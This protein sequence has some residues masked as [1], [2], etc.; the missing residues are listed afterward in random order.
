MNEHEQ[1]NVGITKQI[2]NNEWI[3]TMNESGESAS[4]YTL[5]IVLTCKNSVQCT[6]NPPVC[7]QH[8]D[9]SRR[10]KPSSFGKTEL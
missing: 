8:I 10:D 1:T 3:H 9:M 4:P 5:K 7:K 6:P 2:Q